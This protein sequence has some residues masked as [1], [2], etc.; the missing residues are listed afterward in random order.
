MMKCRPDRYG[1]VIV[2]CIK[3]RPEWDREGPRRPHQ[4]LDYDH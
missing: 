3:E 2:A 1:T 4:A